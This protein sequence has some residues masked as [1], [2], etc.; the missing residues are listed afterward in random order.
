MIQG[1]KAED[2]KRGDVFA[3]L[4][5]ACACGILAWMEFKGKREAPPKRRVVDVIILKNS[6]LWYYYAALR[7]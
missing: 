6:V 2:R 3:A 4:K 1:C 7:S 5:N